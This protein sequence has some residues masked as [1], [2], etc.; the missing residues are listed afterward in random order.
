[1]HPAD[2]KRLGPR[3]RC[4]AMIAGELDPAINWRVTR[5]AELTGLDAEALHEHVEYRR[6]WESHDEGYLHQVIVSARILLRP[7]ERDGTVA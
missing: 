2:F 3:E 6:G 7:D 5:V 4:A 1:M